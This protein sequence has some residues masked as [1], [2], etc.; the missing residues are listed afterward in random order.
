MKDFV[1][2]VSTITVLHYQLEVF[3]THTDPIEEVKHLLISYT[4]L[5]LVVR[6]YCH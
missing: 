1:G 6:Q 5:V 2:S 4:L 3:R